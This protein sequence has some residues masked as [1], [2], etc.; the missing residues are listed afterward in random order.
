M[1]VVPPQRLKGDKATIR[2]VVEDC[3]S[4]ATRG[5]LPQF[6]LATPHRGSNLAESWIGHLGASLIRLPS[7]LQSDIV[8]MVSDKPDAATPTAKAF[9]RQMNFSSVRTLSPRDPRCKRWPISRS[10]CRFTAS[11]ENMPGSDRN[12]QRRV[13]PYTS[14]HL[15]GAS[16]ELVVR[17]GHSVCEN[18][19][20]QREVIRILRLEM[21]REKRGTELL[22]VAQR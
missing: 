21:N 16:S 13:V 12:Q 2:R 5:S 7:D 8:N 18:G 3:I 22:S 6:S 4:A 20:A 14:S 1:F 15:V 19:D 11:S 9:H 17:S 10:M